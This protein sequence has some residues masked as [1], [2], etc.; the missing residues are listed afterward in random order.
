MKI[1]DSSLNREDISSEVQRPLFLVSV[2]LG[3]RFMRVLSTFINNA[4]IACNSNSRS[5][6]VLKFHSIRAA[7]LLRA[8]VRQERDSREKN[9]GEMRK[10]EGD[11]FSRLKIE[12]VVAL[13]RFPQTTRMT[14]RHV[15]H[16]YAN[17][18]L[19]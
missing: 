11:G 1:K 5:P 16:K 9:E 12:R 6:S 13:P 10:R 15:R 17:I 3:C 7:T 8:I 14:A 19:G 2:A 4:E 18:Y